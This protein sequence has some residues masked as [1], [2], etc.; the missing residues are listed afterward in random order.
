M[1]T[2]ICFYVLHITKNYNLVC[3][4]ALKIAKKLM[5]DGEK[6]SS[7][8]LYPKIPLEYILSQINLI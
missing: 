5:L 6:I 8:L 4:K 7:V 3:L 1:S 2:A